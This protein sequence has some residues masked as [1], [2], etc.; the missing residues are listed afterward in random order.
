MVLKTLFSFSFLAM[1]MLPAAAQGTFGGG[2][3]TSANPYIINTAAHFTE[4]SDSVRA[5]HNYTGKYFIVTADIDFSNQN[6]TPIGNNFDGSSDIHYFYGHVDGQNHSIQNFRSEFSES[7]VG[8]FGII[9]AG[10]EL[11][12]IHIASGTV[13]GSGLVGSVLGFNYGGTVT[14]CSAGNQVTVSTGLYY[15]GGVVGANGT[16]GTITGC[17]N[18]ATVQGTGSNGM[19]VGGIAGASNGTIT[20]CCNMGPVSG[21]RYVGG[22]TSYSDEG[23]IIRNCYNG[24]NI[25]A[26]VEYAGGIAGSLMTVSACIIENCYNYGNITAPT[27]AAAICAYS[28]PQTTYTNNHFDQQTSGVSDSHAT[29]QSTAT[30]TG[31]SFAATLNSSTATC[32]NEDAQLQNNGYPV[33]GWLAHA[34]IGG[35]LWIGEKPLIWSNEQSIEIQFATP[36][37]GSIS[38]FSPSGQLLGKETISSL[39]HSIAAEKGNVYLICI[40]TENGQY[41]Q[42]LVH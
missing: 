5:S 32:W 38:L 30:M 16:G 35:S 29:G 1:L 42:K 19:N 20:E 26:S 21:V 8:L 36:G 31:G 14:H 3:G 9:G 17:I 18:Y 33:F 10:A 37:N 27:D 24:G 23:T 39:Q 25:S 13:S 7:G 6:H 41:I 15:V 40:E 34:S 4:L 28:Y 22:I 11:K 2:S 12:N